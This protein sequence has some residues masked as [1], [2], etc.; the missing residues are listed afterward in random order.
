MLRPLRHMSDQEL[1]DKLRYSEAAFTEIYNRY[2]DKLL[3]VSALKLQNTPMAEEIVQEIFLDLWR[4][5]EQLSISVSLEAY[6][7]VAVKY[8]II[9]AQLKIK[10]E[11][12]YLQGQRERVFQTDKWLDEKELEKH[13]QLLISKLP[14]K[15]RITYLLSRE[16]G[17]SL[18]E[19]SLR[20]AVSQKAVEANLTRSLKILRLGLRKILSL[21]LYLASVATEYMGL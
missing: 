18:K 3:Y 15:C 16:A 10:R 6:L 19:I 14:E 7:S 20:M 13:F 11:Q 21:M 8:R 1:V 2:W 9:N 17:L 12:D 4:R 5:R